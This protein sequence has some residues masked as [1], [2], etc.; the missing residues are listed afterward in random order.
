MKKTL[1]FL[2]SAILL[3]GMYPLEV[4][5]VEIIASGTCGD[6]VNWSVYDDGSF[7]LTGNGTLM[8]DY[9]N[10]EDVPWYNYR[11][12]ITDASL[13]LSQITNVGKHAFS[14]CTGLTRIVIPSNVSVI[15]SY[16]F[17]CC[18][19]LKT[20]EGDIIANSGCQKTNLGINVPEIGSYAFYNCSSLESIDIRGE[21]TQIQKGTFSGCTNLN[22]I[23]IPDTVTYV[24]V[25]AFNNCT[26]LS[27]VYYSGTE[28][29]WYSINIE[30]N[31]EPLL[32]ATIHYQGNGGEP[33]EPYSPDGYNFYK[34][35]YYFTNSFDIPIIDQKYFN[36]VFNPGHSKTMK[37]FY[38]EKKESHGVCFGMAYT[39]A[40]I[41][42]GIPPVTIMAENRLS[43]AFGQFHNT[44]RELKPGSVFGIIGAN[45]NNMIISVLDYILYS[46]VY[47][48]STQHQNN[49]HFVEGRSLFS[50]EKL[51]DFFQKISYLIQQNTVVPI[52]LG[53]TRF[54]K[55]GVEVSDGAHAVLAVGIDGHDILL[56]DP[57]NKEGFNRIHINDDFSE[58]S[59]N[60]PWQ[61]AYGSTVN[62]TNSVLAYA[63]DF[64][65][66]Y[67]I[68]QSGT[69]VD[70]ESVT[71][72][73]TM[74]VK[75]DNGTEEEEET[76]VIGNTERLDGDKLLV[77]T[78]CDD[79]ALENED[80]LKLD[81][82]DGGAADETNGRLYWVS[83]DK[84]VTVTGIAGSDNRVSVAGRNSILQVETEGNSEQITMTVDEDAAVFSTV[85]DSTEG[86]AYSIGLLA[87]Y[88]NA[89]EDTALTVSGTASGE[90]I[91]AD[92]TDGNV[93]VT[94][95]NNLTITYTENDEVVDEITVPVTDGQEITITVD[96]DNDT[97][98]TDF[99]PHTEHTWDEGTVTKAPTCTAAGE[100]TFTCTVCG[101]TKV[102]PIAPLGHAYGN[103]TR[104]DDSTHRRVCANDP[105]HVETAAHNWDA[106]RQTKTPTCAAR[107]EF[108]YTCRDCGA[109]KVT[110][111]NT[112]Q[113]KDDDRDG[114]CDYGC[115]TTFTKPEEPHEEEGGKC[116]YCGQRHT[117][118]F[119]G[120]VG[121]F[122]RIAYFFKNL[123]G[124]K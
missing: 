55:N 79:C 96:E 78:N 13:W 56:D 103:W 36:A 114:Y 35:S 111:Q 16:A 5:A 12:S 14:G 4:F 74:A 1:A 94:G 15:N 89:A 95:L 71:T 120:I 90:E 121:F 52:L 110:Y 122:H 38:N 41:M 102:E 46:H 3:L 98:S 97:V 21:I 65:A 30:S 59:Y 28:A 107:G 19:N 100:K 75:Q 44:I 67:Q 112:V 9:E 73:Q 63:Y 39:T 116:P 43:A 80:V 24:R 84:T 91:R 48:W 85:I 37:D 109:T 62:N 69:K 25:G 123:F 32:N 108:T 70:Y 18:I 20:V 101:E 66:P 31:N 68:L 29:E 64:Y 22:S 42:K 6:D 7:L 118:F 54:D 2:L 86:Q 93:T 113:H 106:D 34:D 88:D 26:S 49:R 104:V 40:S 27:D 8:N 92:E 77:Y 33:T 10:E 57:N 82:I 115:G 105:Q 11:E 119:G 17:S 61:T 87:A 83:N 45:N 117:G 53:R 60:D 81:I 58:W 72:T 99:E 124:G 50:S 76:D 47:Q 51:R 23:S